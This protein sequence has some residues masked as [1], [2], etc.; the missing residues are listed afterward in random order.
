MVASQ[1]RTLADQTRQATAAIYGSVEKV[2]GSTS[3][4]VTLIEALQN[5]VGSLDHSA[6]DVARSMESQRAA[7]TDI[8]H[9]V[10]RAAQESG[11]VK[12]TLA[13]MTSAFNEVSGGSERIVELVAELETEVQAL[14]DKSEG[15]LTMARTA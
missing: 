8:A 12:E 11:T 14:K 15:F 3:D 6:A 4:V 9:N 7:A 5:A 10:E 1:V 2:Q 13:F